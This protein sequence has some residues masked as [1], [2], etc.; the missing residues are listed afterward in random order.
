MKKIKNNKSVGKE[1]KRISLAFTSSAAAT[2]KYTAAQQ[3]HEE[4]YSHPHTGRAEAEESL[5]VIAG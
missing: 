2:E 1:A 4:R 5:G 3:V